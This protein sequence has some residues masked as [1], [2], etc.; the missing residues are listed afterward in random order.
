[1]VPLT[2]YNVKRAVWHNVTF[3]RD[4]TILIVENR[5]TSQENSDY[6]S[7]DTGQRAQIVELTRGLWSP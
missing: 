1:M 6:C 7:L 3:S 2:L 4:A 5:D